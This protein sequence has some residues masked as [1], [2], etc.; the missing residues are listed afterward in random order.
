VALTVVCKVP[1]NLVNTA[2]NAAI[3][4]S[5][6]S[7]IAFVRIAGF[8]SGEFSLALSY[9][10]STK[11]TRLIGV[12]AT[13][14]PHLYAY[15]VDHLGPLFKTYPD[16]Q[17]NFINSVFACATFNFGPITCPGNLPFGWCAITALGNF[18][19]LLGGHLIL[20]DLKIV[21]EF[22][23]GSTILIPSASIRHSNIMIRP[24]ESRYSFTQYTAGG[25]FCWVDH[26]YQTEKSY[27]KGWSKARKQAEEDANQQRWVRGVGMFST[28]A[29]LATMSM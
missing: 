5:L 1:G 26:G 21:I 17:R 20:W 3:L 10:Y 14:V 2:I 7:N 13:W 19:P 15:Y 6:L 28:L 23:P 8:A 12:L 24:G 25:L 27:K 18:N 11:L 9:F 22:P 4:Y 29:E 16:L